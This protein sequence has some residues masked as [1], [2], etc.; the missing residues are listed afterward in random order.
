MACVRELAE[1][2]WK[3]LTTPQTFQQCVPSSMPADVESKRLQ[4]KRQREER[5]Q[6]DARTAV[7]NWPPARDTIVRNVD[8]VR[9]LS[10]VRDNPLPIPSE[11]RS[12]KAS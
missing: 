1:V 3:M 12:K 11:L 8:R 9:S 5:K 10:Q 6:S 4:R 2:I 7:A